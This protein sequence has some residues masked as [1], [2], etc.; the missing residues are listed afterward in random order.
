MKNKFFEYYNPSDQEINEV[1]IKGTF[2]FDSN[3][4]L[5]LY[6]YSP[7]ARSAFFKILE[8]ISYRTK[9]THEAAYRFHRYRQGIIQS[10]GIVYKTIR[11]FLKKKENEIHQE[12]NGYNRYSYLEIDLVRKHLNQSLDTISTELERIESQQQ[13]YIESDIIL[14]TLSN[15][16]DD[17]KIG[18]PYTNDRLED[19]FEI[20]RERFQKQIAPGYVPRQGEKTHD[21]H[22]VYSDLIMWFQLIDEAKRQNKPLILVTDELKEDWWERSSSKQH[23]VAKRELLKEFYNE[24]KQKIYFYTMENFITFAMNRFVN[25]VDEDVIQE[26]INIKQKDKELRHVEKIIS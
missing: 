7:K 21:E 6:R 11:D 2:T 16:L 25:N 23:S 4:L 10:Q 20:G 17:S 24:T 13:N 19:I 1:W 8:N 26:I 9:L 12:L 3:A 14:D 15:V 18:E 22:I 5:N